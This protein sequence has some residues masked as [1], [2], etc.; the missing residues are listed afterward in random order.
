VIVTRTP[1]TNI[2][3]IT[4]KNVGF[5][6]YDVE[7]VGYNLSGYKFG[8]E[9]KPIK[10]FVFE[11]GFGISG[12][13]EHG[14]FGV[15]IDDKFYHDEFSK[16][17]KQFWYNSPF[18]SKDDWDKGTLDLNTKKIPVREFSTDVN[19]LFSIN[20]YWHWFCEDLP[21]IE[22]MR[23]NNFPI[24]TNILT[25]WQKQSLMFFPDIL[26]RLVEVETPVIIKAPRYRTFSYPA[27][28]RR[29][30]THK[31]VPRFLN[32][33]LTPSNKN[34]PNELVYISRG[35]AVARVVENEKEVK[36]FLIGKG[37][38][39]YDNFSQ[40]SVQEK[41][42]VFANAKLVV[43]PTGSNLTHCH[44]MQSGTTVVD[45]NHEFELENECGWNSL[46]TELGVRW[47]TFPV[48]TGA[49]GP[50]SGKGLKQ[51]NN[52]LWVDVAVLEKA[53]IHAMA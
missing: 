1:N 8:Y 13:K 16:N 4:H 2:Q 24:V 28:S 3:T 25:T 32:K 45:F 19:L 36:D 30:K 22:Y 15:V 43:A 6:E 31:T 5:R 20:Q 51:K 29:G 26:A 35:D 44:A 49:Q 21:L 50:R 37:F 46:A 53:L 48:K 41:I 9:E 11:N 34:K 38:V 52:N 39:C 27:V 14:C 47:I 33:H 10:E 18:W 7:F 17:G 40:L 12:A 42:N 23:T